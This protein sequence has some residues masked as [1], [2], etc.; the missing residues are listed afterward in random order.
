MVD[1]TGKEHLNLSQWSRKFFERVIPYAKKNQ[2][3]F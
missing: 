2:K 1:N 3:A